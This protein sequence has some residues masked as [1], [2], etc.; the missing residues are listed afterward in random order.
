M[1]HS[2][3]I[4]Q[5]QELEEQPHINMGFISVIALVAG[6]VITINIQRQRK[7]SKASLAGGERGTRGQI[8]SV[9]AKFRHRGDLQPPFL[10]VSAS[11]RVPSPPRAANPCPVGQTL[12]KFPPGSQLKENL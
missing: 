11:P 10:W 3:G 2:H 9:E 7:L 12:P 1:F 6:T 4:T 8:L 5:F